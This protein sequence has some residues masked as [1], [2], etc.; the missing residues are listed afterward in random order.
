MDEIDGL[1]ESIQS[2]ADVRP[3]RV[4]MEKT[5][6]IQAQTKK[7][8]ESVQDPFTRQDPNLFEYF[9]LDLP[10]IRYERQLLGQLKYIHDRISRETQDTDELFAYLRIIERS[11]WNKDPFVRVDSVCKWLKSN[12]GK[13]L[14]E[15]LKKDA[16]LDPK[17]VLEEHG[18][19]T[20]D[21]TGYLRLSQPA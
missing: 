16:L 2:L 14:K 19:E 4:W 5:E 12:R 18:R 20:G 11:F 3:S 10:K 6:P 8:A 15:L 1:D 9:G 21:W 13:P 7:L 17:E